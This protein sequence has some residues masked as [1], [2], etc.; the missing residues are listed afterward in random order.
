MEYQVIVL[1]SG[2]AGFSCAKSL[3]R[4]GYR[5]GL[6]E[7]NLL[8]GTGYRT[9]CL[10][11]KILLDLVQRGCFEERL[12]L[13]PQGN[14]FT[15][16]KSIT[17][18]WAL[19]MEEEL[20]ALGVQILKGEGDFLD[21]RTLSLEGKLLKADTFVLTTGSEPGFPFGLTGKE[22]FLLD[23]KGVLDL[24]KIPESLIILGASVEG[25]E[26]A[27]LFALLG[28]RVTLLEREAEILPGTDRDLVE[29]VQE[30]L[31]DLGVIFMPGW[32]LLGV[33]RSENGKGRA[34]LS[35][36]ESLE[37]EYLLFTG[38]RSPSFPRGL[39]RAEVGIG[40]GVIITD[41][42][43]QTTA[44]NIYALGDITGKSCTANAALHQGRILPRILEGERIKTSYQRLPGAF[45]T[46]PEI[47]G[48]GYSERELIESGWEYRKG[49]APLGA[50]PRGFTRNLS[51]GF[52]KVLFSRENRLLG[53]WMCG[54]QASEILSLAGVLVGR[55]AAPR[56]IED[57]LMIHPTLSEVLLE[58]VSNLEG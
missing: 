41:D 24:E 44:P 30:T 33:E 2:P 4:K 9:G 55:G 48:A 43:F 57:S 16:A 50:A 53:I 58:A 21:P 26:F 39:D 34:L 7:K 38:F 25:L 6:V 46:L 54:P 35:G 11:V 40:G 15:Q 27:G 20:K 45:F 36:N 23:H 8:G 1:G 28:T 31:K 32:E 52:A 49:V 51:R 12:L 18:D 19:K 3:A 56:E 14:L 37:A 47:A 5:T 29:P 42:N 22:A 13:N 17:R 10:P